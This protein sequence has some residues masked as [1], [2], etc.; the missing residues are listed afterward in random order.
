MN[1]TTRRAY[2]KSARG[3][4]CSR[5]GRGGDG[6]GKRKDGTIW[7]G[8]RKEEEEEEDEVDAGS[9]RARMIIFYTRRKTRGREESAG[10]FA[11]E[12]ERRLSRERF[13][14]YTIALSTLCDKYG[15]V[16]ERAVARPAIVFVF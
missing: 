13:N 3:E 10:Y 15:G 11:Y 1:D 9:E 2:A 4:R 8:E 5:N 6:V 12:T 16:R 14:H 7:E